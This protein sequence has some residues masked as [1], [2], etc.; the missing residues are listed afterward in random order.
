LSGGQRQRIGIARALYHDPAVLILDEATSALDGITEE[1]V[2][3]AIRNLSRK[4]TI[5]M[6]AH[7]LTTVKESDLIYLLEHG[8]IVKYGSYND[9]QISSEWFRAASGTGTSVVS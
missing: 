2:M 8:K 3:E 9:L 7:R 4:K 1:A 6:I 5:V